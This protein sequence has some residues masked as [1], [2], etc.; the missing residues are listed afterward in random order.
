LFGLR[1]RQLQVLQRL[2]VHFKGLQHLPQLIPAETLVLSYH[3]SQRSW[4]RQRHYK[5]GG[6]EPLFRFL[7]QILQCL[8]DINILWCFQLQHINVHLADFQMLLQ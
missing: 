3:F 7:D 2:L 4:R 8:L 1:R 6:R 5:A